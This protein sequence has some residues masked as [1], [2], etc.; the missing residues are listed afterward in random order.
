MPIIH[1]ITIGQL[2][3]IQKKS[4]KVIIKRFKTNLDE[5]KEVN[6]KQNFCLNLKEST[7]KKKFR[8]HHDQSSLRRPSPRDELPC[9]T[10]LRGLTSLQVIVYHLYLHPPSKNKKYKFHI[11]KGLKYIFKGYEILVD[12]GDSPHGKGK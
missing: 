11:S 3:G 2:N 5:K 10:H 6:Y 4:A 12:K 8:V 7:P 1:V 9:K